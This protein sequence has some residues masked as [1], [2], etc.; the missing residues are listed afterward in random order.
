ML[1]LE[2]ALALALTEL[3]LPIAEVVGLLS[4]RPAAI[5]GLKGIHG[6]PIESGAPAN[7]CVFDPQE[8]WTVDP[9][10]L[11]SRSRN[12]PYCRAP[13]A[14]QSAPHHCRR[15]RQYWSTRR[16]GHDLLAGLRLD[17]VGDEPM[18]REAA[19]VLS[20]GEVFEGEAIGA[21]P[22]GGI[23]S[24]EVVFNTVLTGYQEVITDPSYAGQIITF[25]YPHIGNYGVA[26]ADHESR[27]TVPVAA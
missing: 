21:E 26:P 13:S 8:T 4:W 14:R 16:C 27:P 1:G 6:G 20:D 23:T 3:D 11:A 10:D 2:T 25:T 15:A 12:T 18:I 9:Y 17:C 24:G 7:L 19:L 5:A 22:A